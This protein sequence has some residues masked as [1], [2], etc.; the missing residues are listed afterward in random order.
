M[1]QDGAKNG[2]FTKKDHPKTLG[3]RVSCKTGTGLG[4][5]GQ[6]GHR[7][8]HNYMRL[9]RYRARQS[10]I[11][12]NAHCKFLHP[13]HMYMLQDVGIC[14]LTIENELTQKGLRVLNFY[15]MGVKLS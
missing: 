3:T 4:G 8:I 9:D 10:L 15:A 5:Q 6:D 1:T 13:A 11:G 2:R 14:T 12:L 7:V